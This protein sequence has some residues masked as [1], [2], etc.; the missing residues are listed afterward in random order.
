[1]QGEDEAQPGADYRELYRRR[2]SEQDLEA[3]G[4]IWGVVVRSFLQR[5]IA[6]ED[7]V[8]DVGCGFGEFL[9]H[10]RCARRVGVDLNPDARKYLDAA[11][12]FRQTSVC[13]LGALPDDS[14][15]VVFSSNVMEH[16]ATKPLVE[17]ML[18]G[19]RRVMKPGAHFI[20]MGPNV[21]FASRNYWDFWDHFVPISDRSLI[22]VLEKLG[23][24]IADCYP[25]FLPYTTRSTL[26]QSPWL[27]W[28]YLKMPIA[29]N[30]LGGQFLIRARKP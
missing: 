30:V 28:L 15:D 18:E 9:N 24:T 13:D 16:L 4:K 27:V 22:E 26:P 5:W 23:F 11:I 3:K 19:I 21:R 6:P 8:L 14:F 29:W 1:M 25:R 20:A 10:V 17:Q 12:D 7:S 2:F